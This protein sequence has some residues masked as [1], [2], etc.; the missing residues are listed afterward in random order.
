MRQAV[1]GV[2]FLVSIFLVVSSYFVQAFPFHIQ[3]LHKALPTPSAWTMSSADRPECQLRAIVMHT[4]YDT[5]QCRIESRQ[6]ASR[7]LNEN[8][9]VQLIAT[10]S[11]EV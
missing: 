3:L 10:A 2:T 4:R 9:S 8:V 11:H 5:Y 1:L 6:R 7:F